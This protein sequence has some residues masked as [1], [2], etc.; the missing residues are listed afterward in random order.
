MERPTGEPSGSPPTH[1]SAVGEKGLKRGALSLVSSVAIGLAS[2]A[3]AY[4]LA[5]TLG[6]I[7]LAVGLQSPVVV[8]LG[9]VPMLFI[10]YAYKAMNHVDAD[11]GTTFTWSA[12]AFGPHTAWLGGWGIIIADIIVMANLAQIAGQYGFQL[13]GA[14]GAAESR[15]W[16]MLAG[17]TWIAVMTF[18]CYIGIEISAFLQK[19]LLSIELV[20]LAILSIT[21]LVKVYGDNPHPESLHVAASW[22]NPFE[23]DSASALTQGVLLA[24]FIYWGWDTAVS[25]NEETTDRER[26]PGRAAVISTVLLLLIYL[27]V[28]TSAQAFAGI[29]EK[30]IGLANPDN[31][32]DVLG[33][34]GDEVFG[35]E[36][37]GGFLSKLLVLMVLTSAAASTQTTILPTA[38]TS[39]SMATHK[40]LPEVFARVH[41]RF[42][43]PTWSTVAMG[44]ASIAF[45]AGLTAISG[46]V[47]EDSIASVGL[48]IA[49]YYGLT[50]FACVWYFRKVLTRS[51][52]DFWLKGV[53]PGLGAVMLLYFFCYAA[54]SV[55]ADPEYGTTVI[56]LP[57]IGDTG[58]VS[59]IGIGALVMGAILMLIQRAVQGSWF[60]N[61]DVPVSHASKYPIQ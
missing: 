48:G 33:S 37:F 41:P 44:L 57:W 6:F 39:F 55:Y 7:V 8:I 1:T 59:V 20:L 26:T 35:T 46:N 2:T 4:S 32:G 21:A 17:V 38:R 34:F 45:Y 10:A 11:C 15:W 9:F 22:F 29:G 49:F 52:A 5:A 16:T 43:T 31:S 36:G 56:D 40:A 3:P 60:R 25:V 58:G 61:P 30:G 50:G 19:W 12:R 24:V 47:L 54:F 14:D 13:V 18:I 28:T 51:A 42:L 23:I 53:L 27:L